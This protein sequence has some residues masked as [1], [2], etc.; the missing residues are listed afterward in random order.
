MEY[1]IVVNEQDEELGVMPRADAHRDGT[2]HRIAVTYVENDRAEI[3]VQVRARGGAHDHSSAGHVEP[4]DSY[5]DTARR[6]LAEE[7]GITNTE[8]KKI[9]H[10]MSREESDDGSRKTHVFDVFVCT[11]EPV[12]LQAGEV[13]RVYWADPNRLLVDMSSRETSIEYAGGFRASL[14]I[15]LA[16]RDERSASA[17]A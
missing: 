7:L 3:L 16:W 17:G 5:I 10:G 4:G 1:V 9:G 2:P 11:A 14:P 15:Y 8:L 12:S 13:T 6:E